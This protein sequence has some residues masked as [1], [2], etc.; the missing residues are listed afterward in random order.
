MSIPGR[1]RT[2]FS[3]QAAL[4]CFTVLV[5]ALVLFHGSLRTT[6]ED[7]RLAAMPSAEAAF[8]YGTSHLDYAMPHEYDIDRAKMLFEKTAALNAKYPYVHHQLARIAFLK[9]DFETALRE[10]NLEIELFGDEHANAYYVRGLIKGFAGDYEGAAADYETYLKS[11]P[12]NWAAINDYAWVLLKDG[13]YRDALVALDW[14]LLTHP[15]NPWLHNSRATALFEMQRLDDAL[16]A[17]QRASSLVELVTTEAWLTAYPG[18]DP[19]VATEGI[20]A[21]KRAVAE[22]MNSIVLAKAEASSHV[23]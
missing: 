22:N 23:R 16:E 21:F 13:R 7:M 6:W 10:I 4:F 19:L 20:A 8:T 18:N 12:K 1:L 15:D 3:W 2:L 9:G 17:A 11:D 5:C 14:G